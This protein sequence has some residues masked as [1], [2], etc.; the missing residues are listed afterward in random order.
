MSLDERGLKILRML[1]D[2]PAISGSQLEKQINLSRKQISYSLEKIN[3]YLK[4]NGYDEIGR[5]KTGKFIMPRNVINSFKTNQYS[6]D[7]SDYVLVEQERLYL[8]SL[9]LLQHKEELSIN[10]FTS[11][12]RISKNTVLN[13]LKKLQNTIL[14]DFDIKIWYDRAK[15][16]YL[17]GKEYEKRTLMIQMVRNML[18]ILT[19]EALMQ[20]ILEIDKEYLNTLR[21]DVEAIEKRLKVQ[22]TDERIR[23]IP[24][25]LYFILIRIHNQKFLDVLPEDYQHIVGTSEYGVVIHIFDKYNIQNTMDKIYIVSQFQVSSV[26]FAHGDSE[27][28]EKKLEDAA[29]KSLDIFENLICIQFKDRES[30]IDALIQHCKP[31]IYR[32][33]YQ[34]HIESNILNL[35]LPHHSYL[36]ELTRHAML[37]YENLIDKPFPE[38]ELAYIT[39][40]FGGWMTKEGTLDIVEHKRKAIVV[41]TNGISI[42]NFLFLKLKEAFPELE[43]ICALSSRRFY[44]YKQDYDLIFTT[45]HLNAQIPQFLVKPIMDNYDMQT[46][47]RKVFNELINKTA[48][49]LDSSSL[50][51]VIEKYV[52]VL[53][54]KGLTNAL[55]SYLGETLEE[56]VARQQQ[57]VVE[58]NNEL[59]Q[60]LTIQHIQVEHEVME[61]K[62]AIEL[63]AQPLFDKSFIT[64][65]Y[66]DKMIQ[67]VEQERPIWTIAD[68]FVLAH[69]GIDEGVNQLGIAMLKL[70]ENIL[71][72]DYME[73]QIIV[74][75]A[76]PNREIHLKALYALIDL[77]ENEKDLMEM[78]NATTKEGLLEIISRKRN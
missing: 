36:F 35:I 64:Q 1:V 66:I 16:Y 6:Y 62:A 47:R 23:E 50:I 58:E 78:K 45:I 26:N 61:W 41:C 4:E 38:E 22:Y 67:S 69:A 31:A 53:D 25:I 9:I 37:P 14:N 63:A 19:G 56:Q 27:Q 76:T 29:N 57:E 52:N 42:S 21:K 77:I 3:Y 30:L 48:F 5:L 17:I 28:Y 65:N 44:E 60:L 46:L 55:K 12:L 51:N 2:N 20:T 10:H 24:Y 70:P 15:G 40:L 8:L 73:A 68:G 39:I 75:L 49:E 43:F 59:S 18:P 11:T 34:Y 32:I 13:D 33:R 71:F 74:V 72:N 7:E 54:R